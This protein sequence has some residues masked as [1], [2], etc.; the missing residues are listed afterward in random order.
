MK[1]RRP[2]KFRFRF[3]LSFFV[4]VE[5]EQGK[6]CELKREKQDNFVSVLSISFPLQYFYVCGF[7]EFFT[8]KILISFLFLSFSCAKVHGLAV[9]EGGQAARIQ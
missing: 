7:N 2:A 6:R 9:N 8:K 3:V 5:L 1:Q 4:S